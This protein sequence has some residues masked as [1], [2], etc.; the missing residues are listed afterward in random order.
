MPQIAK[1]LHEIF[2]HDFSQS[3]DPAKLRRRFFNKH[4]TLTDLKKISSAVCDSQVSIGGRTIPA[5]ITIPGNHRGKPFIIL[6]QL[7]GNEPAGL[8]GI[9]LAMA[10]SKAGKL[11]RDVI[12]VIGNPLAAEQYFDAWTAAPTA[13][14]EV[15]DPYRCGLDKD[16]NLLP[17]MN[18]IP[19]DFM[20]REPSTPHIKRAQEL[21]TL[22]QN[23]CGIADI[24]SARG[25]LVCITDYKYEKHL[26]Y[27][28]IRK[29]L[30]GLA[31]AIS[32]HASSGAKVQTLKTTLA[33]LPNI[34]SQMGI[35]AGRHESPDAPEIA[36]AFTLALLYHLK[37]TSVPPLEEKENG[38]FEQ[39]HV[40]PR[41]TYGDLSH[42]G[43]LKNNDQ[44]FMALPCN[45]PEKLPQKCARV[46]VKKKNGDMAVQTALEYIV[47]PGG[48]LAYA[49][50]QYEEMEA[51]KKGQVLAVAVP[52]GVEFKAPA[53]FSPIFISKSGSLYSK[54]PAVGAWPVVADK[55]ASTKFCYPCDVSSW[56]IDF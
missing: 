40:S 52:S 39:Y 46:I 19:V 26:K 50:H 15:R 47:S 16:G 12:G 36:A 28:P 14:Q 17:D 13:R 48:E 8:A 27:S 42:S 20:E 30:V 54:D 21:Y 53:D 10:L 25:D 55:I 22:G 41:I 38:A 6:A 31:D 1:L 2:N 3:D 35:E 33:P 37:L 29:V 34:E 44:V 5:A 24:H 56:K 11:E 4:L 45:T 7:H 32:A 9:A 23:A 43:S 18:R 51:F 49:V